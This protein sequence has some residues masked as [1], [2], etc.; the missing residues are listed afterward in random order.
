MAIGYMDGFGFEIVPDQCPDHGEYRY[1]TGCSAPN[2]NAASFSCCPEDGCDI[3]YPDSKCA[4]AVAAE[5]EQDRADRINRER[6]AFGLSP[7]NDEVA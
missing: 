2:C 1:D 4:Q 7:I 3:E 6:A 5:S